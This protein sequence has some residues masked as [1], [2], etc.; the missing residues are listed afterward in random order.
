M[1]APKEGF[2]QVNGLPCRVWEKGEGEPLGFL[3]GFGGLPA[4]PPLL[5]LLAEKR[6]VIAPSLPGYPGAL[7]HDLL[8]SPLDWA[9]AVQDLLRG[10]GLEGRDLIGVSVGATLAAEVAA[11]WE[12][13]VRRLVLVAPF[14]LFDEAA[15]VRDLFALAPG[16]L[17]GVLCADGA[18]FEALTAIPEGADEVEWQIEQVRAAEAA[19]RLLW[20]LGST[21]LEKRLHRISQ[22]TLLLWGDAD[23]VIPPSYAKR[24]AE[25]I[26]GDPQMRTIEGAGHLADLDAP[27][28]VA[29]AVAEFLA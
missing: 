5:D 8:D 9:L 25:K 18:K 27:E 6:R 29:E 15:P 19:A 14:G 17:A 1:S 28:Q 20:P 24:F 3:A 7:G 10:A 26:T 11:I 12:A 21:G 23:Q 4:W 16:T 13:M 2:V 22:P